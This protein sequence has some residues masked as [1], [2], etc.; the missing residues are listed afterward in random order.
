MSILLINTTTR[1]LCNTHWDAGGSYVFVFLQ[2]ETEVDDWIY[3]KILCQYSV[4]KVL[5]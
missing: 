4:S 1:L 3:A 2:T 5:A